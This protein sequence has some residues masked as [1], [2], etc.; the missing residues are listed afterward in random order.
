MC[1]RLTS[2]GWLFWCSSSIGNILELVRGFVC[3]VGDI[4]SYGAW[5]S[6]QRNSIQRAASHLP[7]FKDCTVLL[8]CIDDI[9]D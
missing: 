4:L 5:Q 1:E 9:A 2:N 6:G 7:F 3:L 8:F